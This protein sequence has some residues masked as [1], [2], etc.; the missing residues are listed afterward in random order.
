MYHRAKMKQEVKQILRGT[1]PRAM[2]LTLLWMVIVSV[3]S[4]VIQGLLDLVSLG[5]LTA[6]SEMLVD[7]I[8]NGGSMEDAMAEVFTYLLRNREMLIG[9]LVG[10]VLISAVSYLW[11]SIMNA[12]YTGYSL[13]ILKGEKTGVKSLFCA[14][15]KL[16]KVIVTNIL[17]GVFTF[18]WTMLFAVGVVVLLFV[19]FWLPSVPSM[20]VILVAYI[21]L[22]VGA[23]WISLR[24]AM[25]N[26]LLM[27]QN[28]SGLEA[29]RM[30]KQM[31]KGNKRRL[32]V[33]Q[34]SFIGWYLLL[35]AIVYGGIILMVLAVIFAVEGA[36]G[37]AMAVSIL[38]VMLML[39]IGLSMA[40][41]MLL[42]S[43][44][45]SPYVSCTTAR[46]YEFVKGQRKDLFPWVT[47]TYNNDFLE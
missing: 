9:I 30:S 12:S 18:L 6:T 36:A 8:M 47:D 5:S 7:S 22:F 29:I 37:G 20:L 13:A 14:F 45:L 15:P 38:G 31:M 26:Y 27:D 39:V 24:Y 41:G 21:G 4:N 28:M 23:V 25:V 33:L 17:V 1:R 16:G 35:F 44:W 3:G 11:Q 46:F 42:F 40:A 32:F 19:A 2:W 34:L 43:A 10:S